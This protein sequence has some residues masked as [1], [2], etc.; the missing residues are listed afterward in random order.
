MT[1]DDEPGPAATGAG[2]VPPGGFR[3]FDF[4]MAAFVAILLLSNVIGADKAATLFGFRFGAGILF[5]RCPTCS[6][7]C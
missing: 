1:T 5:F 6:A 7:T 3:H 4:M 2:Q